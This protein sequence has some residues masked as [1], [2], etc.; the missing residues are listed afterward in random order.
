MVVRDFH[1]PGVAL[2]PAE[3]DSPLAVDPDAMLAL[4][5]TGKFFQSVARQSAQILK[6]L[7]RVEHHQLPQRGTLQLAI[8]PLDGLALE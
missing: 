1:V 5:I 4:A 8:K 3:A 6:G 2:F 7:G